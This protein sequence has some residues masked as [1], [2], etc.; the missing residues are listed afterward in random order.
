MRNVAVVFGLWL[1]TAG[2]VEK[3]RDAQHDSADADKLQK[4]VESNSSTLADLEKRIKSLEGF[5]FDEEITKDTDAYLRLTSPGYEVV[6]T[7]IGRMT[8]QLANIEEYASGSRVTLRFG[9][10][11]S[12]IVQGLHATI[13]W[14]KVNAKGVPE[15][16]VQHVQQIT[17]SEDLL[18]GVWTE[19]PVV[20]DSVPPKELGFVRF[21]DV[22][23][24]GIKL[25]SPPRPK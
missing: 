3:S 15:Y 10:L 8:V 13:E 25:G 9:N 20:L 16:P 4:Q 6:Q 22:T 11:T 24:T 17:L 12:A 2:C 19:T 18:P 14:G 5:R 1:F 7:N 23:H 21:K